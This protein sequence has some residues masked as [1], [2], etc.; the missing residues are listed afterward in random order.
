[1]ESHEV[2][3][4]WLFDRL[5]DSVALLA[6]PPDIQLREM[7]ISGRKADELFLRFD[8]WRMKVVGTFQS[9]IA[10]DQLFCLDSIQQVF[11]KMG[12]E[13]WS[14][15]GLNNSAEWN[16]VRRLSTQTLEVFGWS[17]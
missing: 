11:L 10:A 12:R 8:H 9:E 17:R 14:D 6:A 1:M 15:D 3:R 13:C 4:I 2:K 16:H 5:K 7:P